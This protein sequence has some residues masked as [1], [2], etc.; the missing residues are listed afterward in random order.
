ML[1]SIF[2]I[3]LGLLI[4]ALTYLGALGTLAQNIWDKRATQGTIILTSIGMYLLVI[5]SHLIS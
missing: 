1:L 5:G 2:L 3:A 4:L